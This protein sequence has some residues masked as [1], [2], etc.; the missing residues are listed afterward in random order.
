MVV[1]RRSALRLERHRYVK[2][3][4]YTGLCPRVGQSGD[5]DLRGL[6]SKRAPRHLRWGL[7]EAAQHAISH[8]L[9]RERYQR[10]KRRHGRLRGSKVAQIDLARQLAQAVW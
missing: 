3:V 10:L 8:E 1:G 9:L 5:V 6:V 2:F 4:G 7:I